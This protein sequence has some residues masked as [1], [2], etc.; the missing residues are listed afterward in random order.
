MMRFSRQIGWRSPRRA[1][2]TLVELLVVIGLM[3]MLGTISV[4]G[5]FAAVRGMTDRGAVQDTVSVIRL[6]M[7]TALIDQTPTAVLF[8]N[9]RTQDED[10]Q[11]G[12]DTGAEIMG[13][14]VAIK[15]AGRISYINGSGGAGSIIVDE[16]ADW[17]QSYPMSESDSS[18]GSGGIRFYNMQ[19]LGDV[20][21]GIEA[22]SSVVNS[23]LSPVGGSD[24]EIG[25]E[26]MINANR[27]LSDW[28]S[29]YK[30]TGTDNM[31]FS[32]VT[33]KNGNNQRWGF[34]IIDGNAAWKPGDPYGVEIASFQLPKGYIFGDSE[35]RDM[36]IKGIASLA[37]KPWELATGLKDYIFNINTV[38]ISAY[39]PGKGKPDPIGTISRKELE[40]DW[41]VSK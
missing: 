34:K 9:C 21:N 36:K 24:S 5:Y 26:Y 3:A 10:V 40:D 16:F 31:K 12:E 19:D 7:Q 35:P 6:A 33:T 20:E 39:R 8:Y 2:F 30:K 17:N 1:A 14:A 32:G 11:S 37:F 29:F 15:M 13:T 4:S 38:T 41:G 23:Y 27:K 25:A 18:S 28:C 22:C